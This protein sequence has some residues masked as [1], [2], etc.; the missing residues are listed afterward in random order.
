MLG[1]AS[2]NDYEVTDLEATEMSRREYPTRITVTPPTCQICNG[3]GFVGC[4]EA[5]R[6]DGRVFIAIA[7]EKAL[8]C[9]CPAGLQFGLQQTEWNREPEIKTLTPEQWRAR[10]REQGWDR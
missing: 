8:P 7:W 1:A 6:D 2:T 10:R 3:Y 9:A 4:P 5:I